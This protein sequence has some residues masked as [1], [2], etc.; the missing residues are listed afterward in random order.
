MD[1]C[2]AMDIL[3]KS[4]NLAQLRHELDC[5]P[6]T[7]L[8]SVA[9]KCLDHFTLANYA[10]FIGNI[11]SLLKCINTQGVRCEKIKALL[12]YLLEISVIEIGNV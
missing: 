2:K 6:N 1:Q 11:N 3:M 8:L 7:S 12:N 4:R 5:L 10:G 9:S